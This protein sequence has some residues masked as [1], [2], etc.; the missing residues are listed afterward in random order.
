[1]V[2]SVNIHGNFLPGLIEHD[3]HKVN[4]WGIS[5][6]AVRFEEGLNGSLIHVGPGTGYTC[7]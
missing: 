2:L 4:E 1:M 6:T 7:G 5:K 3:L